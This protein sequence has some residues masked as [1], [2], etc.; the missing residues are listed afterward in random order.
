MSSEFEQ[1]K[2][3]S[4]RSRQAGPKALKKK[5]KDDNSKTG[6]QKAFAF[7]SAVRAA[8]STRRTLD[9]QSKKH[10]IPVVD[11]RP[12]EP[13]PAVVM[14][15]GPPRVGK[16]T[17]ISSLIKNYTRQSV[18][19]AKGPVTVV[20]G[21]LYSCSDLSNFWVRKINGEQWVWYGATRI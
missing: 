20:S 11:R 15:A 16:S 7:K 8:R 19:D 10:H 5:R 14:V 4:H 13:P 1:P 6:N 12:R 2:G 3:K 21:K 18:V 17:L 9:K